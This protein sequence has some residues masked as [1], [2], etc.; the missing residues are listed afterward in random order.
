MIIITNLPSEVLEQFI[1]N[2]VDVVGIE[3]AW[4]RGRLICRIFADCITHEVL[5]N[6]PATAFKSPSRFSQA[7]YAKTK[8]LCHKRYLKRYL[9]SRMYR[10]NGANPAFFDKIRT[11]AAKHLG[12]L[13]D[14]GSAGSPL[15]SVPRADME[16]ILSWCAC[17][18]YA[19]HRYV[20][21]DKLK[22]ALLPL[23]KRMRHRAWP[24]F[25]AA[26]GD[27]AHVQRLLD[28]EQ[29]PAELMR[30]ISQ[31][32]FP[33]TIN[34][35]WD[36]VDV[37]LERM[38]AHDGSEWNLSEHVL[39][40]SIQ[41]AIKQNNAEGFA[42]L[43]TYFCRC[44]PWASSVEVNVYLLRS[45]ATGNV[46]IFTQLLQTKDKVPTDTWRTIFKTACKHNQA[47]FVRFLFTSNFL[48]RQYVRDSDICYTA[49][50]HGSRA[51]VDVLLAFGADI[52]YDPYE[53]DQAYWKPLSI[54][55]RTGNIVMVRHLLERGAV[56]IP[57]MLRMTEELAM[58]LYSDDWL[59]LKMKAETYVYVF[60]QAQ[61]RFSRHEVSRAPTLR[62][63]KEHGLDG[64]K[65]KGAKKG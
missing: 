39:D 30:Y 26:I 15:E 3:E 28:S 46:D 63:L 24:A 45:A 4:R 2:Y 20:F 12:P 65:S 47:N 1:S 44:F 21:A 14:D 61:W 53:K 60:K 9:T 62:A 22:L 6:Q 49:A 57:A 27:T 33:A 40:I 19:P 38:P 13:N 42:K 5:T 34:G 51:V 35:H 54:A 52:N 64:L 8:I 29:T 50:K 25:A 31:P 18:Q 56:L 37:L 11:M 48:D 16:Q 43:F 23:F 55:I 17:W 41:N 59:A 7:G 32:L 36:T 58:R 10:L